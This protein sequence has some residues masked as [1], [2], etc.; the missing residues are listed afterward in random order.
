HELRTPLNAIIGYTELLADACFGPITDK[1]QA[2]L[3]SVLEASNHLL[4][5]VNQVLDLSRAEAGEL[6]T[7]LV[8][9]DV[10]AIARDTARLLEPLTRSR[11][12]EIQVLGARTSVRTDPERVRQILTN[13][14]SN[15][16]KFTRA[17][18]VT[19]RVDATDDGAR[20]VVE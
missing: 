9:C 17:G 2:A 12:Y 5:L 6:T 1:Q 19:V 8:E 11:P 15:A 20:L 16:I 7:E 14:L 18:S 3:D 13:L 4:Q 10:L